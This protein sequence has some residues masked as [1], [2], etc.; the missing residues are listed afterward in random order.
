MFKLMPPW[1]LCRKT[2]GQVLDKGCTAGFFFFCSSKW[3]CCPALMFLLY[4]LQQHYSIKCIRLYVSF[5]IHSLVSLCWTKLLDNILFMSV[6]QLYFAR[7]PL[8][9]NLLYMLSENML[10]CN[11]DGKCTQN[12]LSIK[13]ILKTCTC[14][15][16]FS[17]KYLM[18]YRLS[19]L[20][21]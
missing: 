20:K 12:T 8:E 10:N 14:C 19:S 4:S 15:R 3:F 9:K 16:H 21:C 11:D 5:G 18:F 6:Y 7:L 13:M 2:I 17:L 1:M